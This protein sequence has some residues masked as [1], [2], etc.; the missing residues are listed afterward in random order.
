MSGNIRRACR[1]AI[2]AVQKFARRHQ[3]IALD[4]LAA[5]FHQRCHGEARITPVA[6]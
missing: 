1:P 2:A 5:D 3:L 4:A 6:D